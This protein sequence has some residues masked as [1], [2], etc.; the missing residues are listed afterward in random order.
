M[1]SLDDQRVKA[2]AAADSE[3]DRRQFRDQFNERMRMHGPR[4]SYLELNVG[5]ARI[6]QVEGRTAFLERHFKN[7]TNAFNADYPPLLASVRHR[8]ADIAARVETLRHFVPDLDGQGSSKALSE[9]SQAFRSDQ[10]RFNAYLVKEIDEMRMEIDAFTM[11][12]RTANE[13]F[14]EL[15]AA[16]EP[17]FSKEEKEVCQKYFDRL[18]ARVTERLNEL[19]KL[20]D[21]ADSQAAST[22]DAIEQ[23]F[24]VR[25]PF[26]KADLE[27]LEALAQCE[28]NARNKFN[29]LRFKNK[30]NQDDVRVALDSVRAAQ[31]AQTPPQRKINKLYEVM[32][33]LRLQI[34]RRAKY[35]GI[36][37]HA[38]STDPIAIDIDFVSPEPEPEPEAPDAKKKPKRSSSTKNRDGS[39]QAEHIP[40]LQNQVDL[41]GGEMMAEVNNAAQHYYKKQKARKFDI[42]R[43]EIQ[44]TQKECASY[45]K[46]Q[47][48]NIAAGTAEVVEI[49]GEHLRLQVME[50]IKVIRSAVT[51]IFQCVTSFYEGAT[52]ASLEEARSAFQKEIATFG[53]SRAAIRERLTPQLADPNNRAAFAA[54][55]KEEETRVAAEAKV[56]A[57]YQ[58]VIVDAEQLGM[59]NFVG[60]LPIVV[61]ETLALLDMFLLEEDVVS[62]HVASPERATLTQMLKDQSRRQNG[63]EPFDELRPFRHRNWPRLD[64]VMAPMEALLGPGSPIVAVVS[65]KGRKPSTI[66]VSKS[67]VEPV[68]K[69]PQQ[70][71]LDTS[72]TRGAI[73]ER[74]ACYGHYETELQQRIGSFKA[75]VNGI[76]AEIK[77]QNLNWR[78]CVLSLKPGIVF[79]PM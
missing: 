68:D 5:Q 17:P 70:T 28:K 15:V 12:Y 10:R 55:L 46:K 42:T 31:M 47:W 63:S 52:L 67:G 59:K 39:A 79:P 74:N 73:V 8:K 65:R 49:S 29:S 78:R 7:T 64:L 13:R 60:H 21:E 71:S 20:V 16:Q 34:I 3:D 40:T 36:L 27:F 35:I 38:F 76:G 58:G 53:V 25:L 19:T 2:L 50:S 77:A 48:G 62:G 33:L 56:I 72:L 54:L 66:R 18:N 30:Q 69:T 57:A 22:R 32:D 45:W 1:R 14:L 51:T 11:G 4:I 6:L 23:D 37:K 26:H 9:L 61:R 44:P 75:E 24:E 43:A 41:I